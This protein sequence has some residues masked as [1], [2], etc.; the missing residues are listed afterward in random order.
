MK[1]FQSDPYS[2]TISLE[3][4]E[5]IYSKTK[6]KEEAEKTED[7]EQ[8]NIIREEENKNNS[9]VYFLKPGWSI[10]KSNRYFNS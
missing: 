7:E 3:E 6:E 4:V 9:N 2:F 1:G 10:F 8:L 5:E